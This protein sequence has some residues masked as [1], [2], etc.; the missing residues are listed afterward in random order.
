[1]D[2]SHCSNSKEMNAALHRHLFGTDKHADG[3]DLAEGWTFETTDGNEFLKKN[4]MRVLGSALRAFVE[5]DDIKNC[6]VVEGRVG[7]VDSEVGLPNGTAL[8]N[9]L[10]DDVVV[11]N[12]LSSVIDAVNNDV[13]KRSAYGIAI[14]RPPVRKP[15]K[16]QEQQDIGASSSRQLLTATAAPAAS[17]AAPQIKSKKRRK[18]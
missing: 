4:G 6:S 15:A 8:Q 10:L 16:A 1:M 3:T 12:T 5:N 9:H 13:L 11:D 2:F 17:P 14:F 7:K 18:S